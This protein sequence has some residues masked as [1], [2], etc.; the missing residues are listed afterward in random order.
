MAQNDPDY[1]T[2]PAFS[3]DAE[4]SLGAE[5]RMAFIKA[6]EESGAGVDDAVSNTASALSD[7]EVLTEVDAAEF[8][9]DAL[10]SLSG[11]YKAV[12]P[13]PAGAASPAQAQAV[14]EAEGPGPA[15]AAE[16]AAMAREPAGGPAAAA[17]GAAPAGGPPGGPAAAAEDADVT[18]NSAPPAEADAG[19]ASEVDCYGRQVPAFGQDTAGYHYNLGSVLRCH[20]A[21][22]IMDD[23]LAHGGT[24]YDER[25]R[26][27]RALQAHRSDTNTSVT[28][29]D[30]GSIVQIAPAKSGA[31]AGAPA[32]A[33]ASGLDGPAAAVAHS[34]SA[35]VTAEADASAAE[36][37]GADDAAIPDD[38]AEPA[39]YSE[40]PAARGAGCGRGRGGHG[41]RGRGRAP[42]RNKFA[43]PLRKKRIIL[44]DTPGTMGTDA[45]EDGG[46][47]GTSA[48]KRKKTGRKVPSTYSARLSAAQLALDA[49][50]PKYGRDGI[51]S[52][53]VSLHYSHT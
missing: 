35:D 24:G 8:E 5:Y 50:N 4:I 40:P 47:A 41:G 36:V 2:Q 21:D 48:G 13:T 30:H 16:T 18:G 37:A 49:P 43:A 15:A 3:K 26:L 12:S 46:S 44:D 1:S 32:A 23:H 52:W 33:P 42:V 10:A 34:T 38:A 14:V 17:E 31:A 51:P 19:T 9:G 53:Q 45:G 29:D 39:A 22:G 25:K 6:F 28:L 7:F 20:D 27:L 11:T